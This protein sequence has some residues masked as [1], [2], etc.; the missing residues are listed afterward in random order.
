MQKVYGTVLFGTVKQPQQHNIKVRSS[1]PEVLLGKGVLKIRCKFTGEHPRRS[2]ISIRLQS[3][4]I[5]IT[6]RHGFSP[7]N[8]LHIF[9]T[10]FLKN[11]FGRLLLKSG[12][13]DNASKE[14]Y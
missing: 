5:G 12:Q 8:L 2:A 14:M 13:N 7:A 1:H 10:P 3:N 6:F 11:T 9:R 4:F